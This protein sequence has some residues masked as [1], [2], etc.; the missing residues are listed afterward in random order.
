MVIGFAAREAVIG[1][2]TQGGILMDTEEAT[3]KEAISKEATSKEVTSKEVISKEVNF[4]KGF[5]LNIMNQLLVFFLIAYGDDAFLPPI[6]PCDS[7]IEKFK[8]MG[9][10]KADGYE[11]TRPV[12][13]GFSIGFLH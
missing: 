11:V 12:F 4:I 3:S 13:L 10:E 6:W 7:I 8:P 5:G 9:C 1:D 2:N